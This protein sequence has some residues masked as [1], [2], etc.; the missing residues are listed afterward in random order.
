MSAPMSVADFLELGC[1]SNAL[2]A[3]KVRKYLETSGDATPAQLA[4]TLIRDGLLTRFQA[5]QLLAGKQRSFLIGGKYKVLDRIGTGGMAAVYLCE[6]AAL[7]RPVAVKVLPAAL[8]E[9][10][11]TRERFQREARATAA[12]DHPNIV[13]AFDVGQ[14]G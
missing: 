6:H 4:D 12:L 7:G 9:D 8:A 5:E 14:D 2:D 11:A 10:H 13:H 1:K 3:D